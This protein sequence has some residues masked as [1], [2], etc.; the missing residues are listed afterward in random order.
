MSILRPIHVI[1]SME[2]FEI[3]IFFL[4][5]QYVLH[6]ADYKSFEFQHSIYK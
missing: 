1:R 2:E 4:I 6:S 3:Q 5:T